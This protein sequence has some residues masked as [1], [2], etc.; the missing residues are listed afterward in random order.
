MSW[1]MLAEIYFKGNGVKQ[2]YEKARMRY[3]QVAT[4]DHLYRGW[5]CLRLAEIYT[6][7][8]GVDQDVERGLRVMKL[9]AD[10]NW[11]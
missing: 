9:A 10:Q 11:L 4:A 6:E 5:G 2:D 7:G 8:L 3:E 1:L